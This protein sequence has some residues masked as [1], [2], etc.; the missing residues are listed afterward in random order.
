MITLSQR[1]RLLCWLDTACAAGARLARACDIVGLSIRTVQRWREGDQPLGGDGRQ[2]RPFEPPNRLSEAE[3]AQVLATANSP[4]FAELTP[5]QIVPILAEQGEYVASEST[6]YRILREHGQLTHRRRS[7]A[8]RQRRTPKALC[9]R[10][11]NEVHT[12]D[13]TYLP[14]TVKGRFFYLYLFMDLYSRKIV[15]WQVHDRE[16]NELAAD[17]VSEIARREGV[18]P[19]QI[20]LHA[21]NGGP[22]K[23]ATMLATLQRLGI[24]PSFS[25]PS[26]SNDN[27]FSESLFK[28]LKYHPSYPARAFND[29]DEARAWVEHFVD[30]Y[31]HRHR[32]SAIKYV[33]PEQRHTGEDFA[34]LARR[35]AVY[36]RAKRRSPHR[37]TGRT[38]NWSPIRKV[39]L[40]P[41]KPH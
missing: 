6:F 19:G 16:C 10:A 2:S 1:E 33:T 21:D 37:W 34:I 24:V 40:N 41:E 17:I 29:L 25:R 9:A 8:P 26:V 4:A 23:G 3:R 12:W 11:A 20:T 39:Y 5:A 38:R 14:T 22:M 7:R 15:G 18:E 36:R 27:A 13:I 31:N 30:W 28:T 32:H 35:D